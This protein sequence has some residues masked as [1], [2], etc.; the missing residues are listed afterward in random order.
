M[1]PVAAA[2]FDASDLAELVDIEQWH[3]EQ[4]DYFAKINTYE[5]DPILIDDPLVEDPH[6]PSVAS[7]DPHSVT[8]P[9][10]LWKQNLD[11][12]REA[13]EIALSTITSSPKAVLEAASCALN[14]RSVYCPW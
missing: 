5:A 10:K 3:T 8:S 4:K 9:Q 14:R 6:D 7:Q 13:M 11:T 1:A 2:G 12:C